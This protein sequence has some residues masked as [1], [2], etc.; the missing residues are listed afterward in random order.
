MSQPTQ[1]V[2]CRMIKAVTKAGL[3]IG[4]V[5]I[6]ADGTIRLHQKTESKP[7]KPKGPVS[8]D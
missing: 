5:E 2:V 6:A 3:E 7:P 8:W 4:T 1:A